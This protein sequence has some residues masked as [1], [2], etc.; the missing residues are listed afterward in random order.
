MR[1]EW[2][3]KLATLFV[4]ALAPLLAACDD[5]AAADAPKAASPDVGIVTVKEEPFA[6]VRE[7]P[8][9]VAPTRVADSTLR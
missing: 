8:G 2:P 3:L 9:R 5:Q 6:L 7:L 1:I 4:V